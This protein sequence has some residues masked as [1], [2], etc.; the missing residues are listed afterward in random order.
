MIGTIRFAAL[1]L[2]LARP[3]LAQLTT[4]EVYQRLDIAVQAAQ[5]D[6]PGGTSDSF[7]LPP[8]TIP[9]SGSGADTLPLHSVV[10]NRGGNATASAF[11]SW[12]M[13]PGSINANAEFTATSTASGQDSASAGF[14]QSFRISYQVS[15]PTSYRLTGSLRTE[16]KLETVDRLTC[17]YNQTPL[18][19]ADPTSLPD[20]A[21]VPFVHEGVLYPGETA[22][23]DCGVIGGSAGT[24]SAVQRWAFQV[25]L[26]PVPNP[27]TSTTIPKKA[28]KQA[29]KQAKAECK[30]ACPTTGAE[31]R[32]CRKDCKKRA[33]HCGQA[34]AC[35]LPAAL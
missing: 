23:I 33:K 9:V 31:K 27:T 15:A 26:T 2:L 19:G 30:A 34:T 1:L 13:S 32:A 7:K 10:A 3:A 8:T 18:A 35:T 11:V 22:N 24:D 21:E 29:C 25:E 6:P 4:G 5:N 16:S 17:A 12:S 28:C 20:D 14:D